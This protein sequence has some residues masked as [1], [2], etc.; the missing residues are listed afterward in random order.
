MPYKDGSLTPKESAFAEAF[1]KWGDRALAEK[2]AGLAQ[3]YGYKMLARPEVLA[4]IRTREQATLVAEALPEA[5]RTLILVMRS[6]KAPA[7]ARVQAAKVVLDRTL[8]ATAESGSKDL[9]ELTPEELAAEI[10]KLES[11]AAALATPVNAPSP[12]E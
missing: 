11:A 5:V 3:N 9:H 4:E 6:D 10:A 8:G 12:F 2:E 1:V 7:A